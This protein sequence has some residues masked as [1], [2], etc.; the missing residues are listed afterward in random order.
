MEREIELAK[1][2]RVQITKNKNIGI[3]DE[4]LLKVS[5]YVNIVEFQPH[6]YQG[7]AF[8]GKEMVMKIRQAVAWFNDKSFPYSSTVLPGNA[9]RISPITP[10]KWPPVLNG[11]RMKM[12]KKY[13]QV[14]NTLLIER[15][16]PR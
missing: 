9:V 2:F 8:R 1:D 13:K 5:E 10:H 6:W 15:F 16:D 3:S 12:Q 11:I 4:D 7:Y 14:F